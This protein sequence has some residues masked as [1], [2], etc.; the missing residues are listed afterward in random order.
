[1]GIIKYLTELGRRRREGRLSPHGARICNACGGLITKEQG[2]TK[3]M[4]LNFHRKCWRVQQ[5][6]A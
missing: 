3:R 1:M 2:R 4:G 6:N 5:K